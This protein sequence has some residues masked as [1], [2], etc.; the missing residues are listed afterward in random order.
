MGTLWVGVIQDEMASA[1]TQTPLPVLDS[2]KAFA[3][4]LAP[5]FGSAL[6][7]M[8]PALCLGK[9]I[10]KNQPDVEVLL[11]TMNELPLT[12]AKF[13]EL[14]K[15][16]DFISMRVCV[17]GVGPPGFSS[18]PYTASKKAGDKE[19]GA[20]LPLYS[21]FKH[22]KNGA[23]EG[24]TRFHTWKKCT[25]NKDR[26]A[27]V[28]EIDVEEGKE[29]CEKMDCTCALPAGLCLS[30]FVQEENLFKGERPVLIDKRSEPDADVLPAYSCIFAQITTKNATQ[31]REGSMLKLKR[32]LVL[33]RIPSALV[34]TCITQSRFPSMAEE[35]EE[36]QSCTK[37]DFPVLSKNIYVGHTKVFRQRVQPRWFADI[38]V[39]RSDCVLIVNPQT[40]E[41]YVIPVQVAMQATKGATIERAVKLLNLCIAGN[42]VELLLRTV[43]TNEGV[44]M[45]DASSAVNLVIFLY[46]DFDKFLACD[47]VNLAIENITSLITATSSLYRGDDIDL[48]LQSAGSCVWSDPSVLFLHRDS[49][50]R[51]SE[52]RIVFELQRSPVSLAQPIL[53]TDIDTFVA[54]GRRGEFYPLRIYLVDRREMDKFG[55]D[56]FHTVVGMEKVHVLQLHPMFRVPEA[57]V[58]G[59]A[60]LRKKRKRPEMVVDD[61]DEF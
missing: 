47:K 13:K 2:N 26:G 25:N 8:T 30:F 24:L 16:K 5:E 21:T 43:T 37:L 35:F 36:L 53:E 10:T 4:A 59:A 49:E 31:A 58:L 29:N 56:D 61:I 12:S 39:E 28:D 11:V 22:E 7:Q 20:L 17:L 32:I 1:D 23:Y 57:E 55:R 33:D 44:I 51:E 40:Y 9:N 14:S 38:D 46:V 27:R 3:D 42:A 19:S 60:L 48:S 52:K 18:V 50:G 45:L 54:D 41:E 34:K 6:S 15:G